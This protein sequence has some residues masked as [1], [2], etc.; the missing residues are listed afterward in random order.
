MMGRFG[1]LKDGIFLGM[2]AGIL[3]TE[4][5]ISAWLADWLA[6]V[7]PASYQFVGTYSILLYGAGIGAIIGYFIDAS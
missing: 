1:N 6:Q 5:R 3:A 2:G 4:P 7:I